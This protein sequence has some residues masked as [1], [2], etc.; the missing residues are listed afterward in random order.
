VAGLKS[1]MKNKEYETAAAHVHQYLHFDPAVVDL[2]FSSTEE[3]RETRE[4]LK[5]AETGFSPPLL[6]RINHQ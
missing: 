4:A 2:L 3:G 1:A 6:P 5:N